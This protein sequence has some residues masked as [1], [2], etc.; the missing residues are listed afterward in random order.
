MGRSKVKMGVCFIGT[1]YCGWQPQGRGHQ[2]ESVH[3][4][5]QKSLRKTLRNK[6]SPVASGRTDKGVHAKCQMVHVSMPVKCV[7]GTDIPIRDA[8]RVMQLE[9]IRRAVNLELPPDIRVLF[10]ADTERT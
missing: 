5:L 2:G 6:S 7:P 10:M 4:A 3:F 9:D 1:Q 8:N